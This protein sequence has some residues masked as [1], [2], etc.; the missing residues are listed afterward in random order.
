MA[1]VGIVMGSDSDMPVMAKAAEVLEKLGIEYE[2]NIIS[3]HREPDIFFEYAKSAESRGYK[4][5]I[6]G[7]G[8]A[9]HLP[10]M[11]AALFPLP[12][13]GI[14]MKTSDLGG[15]DSLYSIVQMPT[16][17]PVATVAINGGANA[18]ILAAKILAASDPELLDRLKAYCEAQKEEVAAKDAKLQETGWKAYK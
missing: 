13:I 8:K 1:K 4:V 9:A 12:V 7:A 10:G 18:G 16:G 14:P 6:A 11:C 17:I 5:I 2:M 3:A 15:V